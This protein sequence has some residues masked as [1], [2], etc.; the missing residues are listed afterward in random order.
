MD[1]DQ[2][3][4]RD[5]YLKFREAVRNGDKTLLRRAELER[6]KDGE[7]PQKTLSHYYES[8]RTEALIGIKAQGQDHRDPS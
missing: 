2:G 5:G 4:D 7:H 6:Q 1:R 3:P 8:L